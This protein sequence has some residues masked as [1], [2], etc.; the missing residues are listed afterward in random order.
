M[1]AITDLVRGTSTIVERVQGNCCVVFTFGSGDCLWVFAA[2]R[3]VGGGDTG[4][5]QGVP[6]V[7]PGAL[8]VLSQFVLPTHK[9]THN[10][11]YMR[12]SRIIR[13]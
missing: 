12:E 6:G 10:S 3:C 7:K 1:V 11:V 9:G 4:D 8:A 5:L 2:H 13:E